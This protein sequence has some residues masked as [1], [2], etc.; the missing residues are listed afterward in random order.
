MRDVLTSVAQRVAAPGRGEPAGVVSD[1]ARPV[2]VLGSAAPM[3]DLEVEFRADDLACVAVRDEADPARVGLITR[4]RFTGA[5][6]G[7]LGYGRA[8]LVRRPVADVTDWAP[9][10]VEPGATV[11]EVATWAMERAGAH[12]Y[13]EVLVRGE[14]WGCASAA[15]LVLALV[16]ALAR[17]STSDPLTGL[18]TRAA[19][20]HTLARRCE[21]A[22]G[23]RARVVLVLLD[24]RG[25]AEL[26]ARH[27][28]A[29]GDAVL[30]ELARAL[31]AALPAGCEAGRVD[32]ARFAVLATMPPTDDV[33][34]AT[35]ADGLRQGLV[36][37]LARPSG[38]VPVWPWLRSSVVWSAAGVTPDP[39]ELVRAAERRLAQGRVAA[40]VP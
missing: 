22:A 34:S 38:A 13:D 14:E 9:L 4:A 1:L 24:V 35:A 16:G 26:N 32:G 12:R 21:L 15:D 19:T 7:R 5:M 2:R 29:V 23:G 6:T 27:G 10:V 36:T 25:M 30:A 40:G 11:A 39:E 18:A 28:Q 8:V 31:V 20:W 33:R 3:A 37:A 17:R